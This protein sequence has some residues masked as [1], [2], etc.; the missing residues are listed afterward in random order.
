MGGGQLERG[1][2]LKQSTQDLTAL[3]RDGKCDSVIGRDEEIR[4]TIQILSRRTKSN[5]VLVGSAGVGKTAVMEGLAQCIVD[6]EVPESFQG[7]RIL[8]LDLAGLLA[9]ASYR[10]A[11][12]ER[13]RALIGDVEAEEGNIIVFIDESTSYSVSARQRV[14]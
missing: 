11:F 4:R 13:F 12:E 14:A 5:P 8:A 7:K 10:G 2:I 3:A 9:G 6:K 1:A